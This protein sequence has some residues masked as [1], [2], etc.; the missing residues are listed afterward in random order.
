[1]AEVHAAKVAFASAGHATRPDQ[2]MLW[3]RSMEDG[4]PPGYGDDIQDSGFGAPEKD[5][6][7]A[8]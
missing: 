4:K 2:L 6:E 7:S 5:D 3:N 8:S 1:M